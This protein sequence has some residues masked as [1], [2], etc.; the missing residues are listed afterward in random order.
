MTTDL[1]P[2]EQEQLVQKHVHALLEHFD[3]VQ[4]LVS[5]SIAEGTANVFLGGGNWFARQGMAHEFI[6]KDR[7]QTEALELSKVIPRTRSDDDDGE[8]WKQS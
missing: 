5:N 6:R 2:A 1:T 7:A 3:C 4:I 8:S